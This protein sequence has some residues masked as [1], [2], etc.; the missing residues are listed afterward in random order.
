M[1]G[2]SPGF[3]APVALAALGGAALLARRW[4]A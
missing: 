4:S 3:G 1:S 2:G